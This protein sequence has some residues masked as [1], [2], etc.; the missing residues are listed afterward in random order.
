MASQVQPYNVYIA[1]WPGPN[2]CALSLSTWANGT[3]DKA[4]DSW[5]YAPT[6]AV[7]GF[8][9]GSS[10]GLGNA[11]GQLLY[12][13]DVGGDSIWTHRVRASDGKVTQVGRH[14]VA[15]G[16]HPRHLAVHPQGQYLYSVM[17]AG[18]RV[19]AF[20]LSSDFSQSGYIDEEESSYSLL[21][22]AKDTAS[23]W[24]AEVMLSQDARYLWATA[25]AQQ[26]TTRLGYI[27]AFLLDDDGTIVKRMFMVP[28]TT[29]GG[30]ANAIAPA[31]WGPAW[32]AM[33][34]FGTGYVQMWR[35]TGRNESTDGVVEYT[36]ATAVARVD[37]SDGGCCANVAWYD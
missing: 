6:S 25:R 28:T 7:H 32:A 1:S 37:I 3:L 34:D 24:S 35:M 13:A 5:G 10:T 11:G 12:S 8:A 22:T 14:T 9:L 4:I 26:N 33:A 30:I 23:Y 2:A 21:P 29:K 15:A 27:S 20:S 16:S 31:P 19:A 17:E 18:N 36:S